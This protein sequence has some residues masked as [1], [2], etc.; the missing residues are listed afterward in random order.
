MAITQIPP[1]G[2]EPGAR[3]INAN[4]LIING[5]AA[6]AQRSA[7]ATGKTASGYYT[8]DRFKLNVSSLG[9]WTVAQE[10][11]TTGDAYANG[12]QKAFRIDCT[13]AA[14]SP[15]AGDYLLINYSLFY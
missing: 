4:P 6:V 2:I 15:G 5:D 10:T 7:S 13:T 9:T 3:R 8:C 1:R 14:A 11:L 12:F